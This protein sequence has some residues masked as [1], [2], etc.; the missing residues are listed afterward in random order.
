MDNNMIQG[1][2][3][4]F[5]GELQN[6][7]GKLSGDELER[8]KGNLTAIAGLIR[9]HYGEAKE[10]LSAKLQEMFNRS[11]AEAADKT[12]EVKED[13]KNSG[14]PTSPGVKHV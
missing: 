3:T 10:D 9:Q 13:L 5:K 1:K 2:W 12:E 11:G 6:A 14:T 7:W 8:T 4:Q